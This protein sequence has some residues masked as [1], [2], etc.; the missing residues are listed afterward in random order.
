MNKKLVFALLVI[1]WVSTLGI[2][3]GGFAQEKAFPSKPIEMVCHM[4]P[5]G[6]TSMGMRVVAGTLTEFLG[7]P[8]VVVHK[9]GGGGSIAPALVARA[10][11]DGYTLVTANSNTMAIAPSIRAV[12]YKTTDFEH[13]VLYATESVALAVKSDAPWKNLQELVAEAKKEPGKLKTGIAGTGS[14][15]HFSMELFKTAAGGL[16]I[17]HVFY[18]SGPEIVAAILGGHIHMSNLYFS[19]L[20]APV[21]AGRL[22]ILAV[23]TEK[24]VEGYPDIPTF[25]ELGL[26]EVIRPVWYGLSAPAGLP[27]EVSGKLK[28]ALYSTVKHPEVKKMLA[29]LGYTPAF[30]EAE[31]FSKFQAEEERK[32]QKIAKEAGIHVE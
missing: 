10:K 29:H 4:G 13:L 2:T 27:K 6:S 12:R 7:V 30:M 1:G 21:G 3:Q 8:V 11:P 5:G 14:S 9:P 23:A 28:P 24:R 17:G 31:E 19:D 25:A 18:K 22:R 20:R 32:I 16:K 26:P 15:S